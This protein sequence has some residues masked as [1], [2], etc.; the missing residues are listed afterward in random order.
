MT[1]KEIDSKSDIHKRYIARYAMIISKQSNSRRQ[2][3][4]VIQNYTRDHTTI[5]GQVAHRNKAKRNEDFHHE[6]T[7][8]ELDDEAIL[9]Y[10]RS[11]GQYRTPTKTFID[12]ESDNKLIEHVGLIEGAE[13]MME[14]VVCNNGYYGASDVIHRTRY[15]R[16]I[17]N[18]LGKTYDKSDLQDPHALDTQPENTILNTIDTRSTDQEKICIKRQQSITTSKCR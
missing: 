6:I 5:D 16:F 15:A 7:E 11:I 17:W 10:A 18:L 12:E 4:R 13:D 14:T 3:A 1:A 9:T 8:A 2:E